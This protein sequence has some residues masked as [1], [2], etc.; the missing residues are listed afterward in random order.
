[1]KLPRRGDRW[2]VQS[3]F[4]TAC[5]ED[6]G[7]HVRRRVF[8]ADGNRTSNSK[9]AGATSNN[10]PTRSLNLV[11]IAAKA[12]VATYLQPDPRR[13]PVHRRVDVTIGAG[14]YRAT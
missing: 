4:S 2:K 10:L 5:H 8:L 13:G 3:A 6:C 7:S 1:M 12:L 14:H 9:R 11:E